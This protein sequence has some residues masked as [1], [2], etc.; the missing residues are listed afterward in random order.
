LYQRKAQKAGKINIKI[1]ATKE[2]ELIASME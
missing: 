1:P 2:K